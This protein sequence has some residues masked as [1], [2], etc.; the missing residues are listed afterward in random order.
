LPRGNQRVR[1]ELTGRGKSPPDVFP[2]MKTDG[3]RWCCAPGVASLRSSRLYGQSLLAVA[4]PIIAIVFGRE[5]CTNRKS[6]VPEAE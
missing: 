6:G 4:G 5:W 3:V 2:R 1:R